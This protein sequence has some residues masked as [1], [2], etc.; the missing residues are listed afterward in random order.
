M[1]LVFFERSASLGA[2]GGRCRFP[3]K[4]ASKPRPA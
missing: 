4:E 2:E 1:L 3:V